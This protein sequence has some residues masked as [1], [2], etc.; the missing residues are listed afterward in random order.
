SV[1]FKKQEYIDGAIA[2]QLLSIALGLMFLSILVAFSLAASNQQKKALILSLIG[3][4]VNVGLNIIFV[5]AY[6][7][8][9]TSVVTIV[10]ELLVLVPGIWIIVK[11]AQ[12]KLT[13]EIIPKVAIITSACILAIYLSRY[14][15]I[16]LQLVI[17]ALIYPLAIILTKAIN[18]EELSL[19]F[20]QRSSEPKQTSREGDLL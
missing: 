14:Q 4:L 2:L 9:A 20:G 16:Y 3:V 19:I 17:L 7:Y 10:T 5:P 12:I 6:G 11:S 15:T 18:R 8:L 1:M 13:L